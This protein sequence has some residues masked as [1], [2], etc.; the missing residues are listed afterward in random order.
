MVPFRI[1]DESVVQLRKILKLTS[2]ARPEH[3]IRIYISGLSQVGPEWN[4]SLDTY[5][6]ETDECCEFD[7]LR[8]IVERELLEAVGGLEVG[9]E[10]FDDDEAGGFVIT[11][12]DPNV[13][14]LYSDSCGC[15]GGCGGCGGCCHHGDEECDEEDHHCCGGGCCHHGDDDDD[16]SEDHHCHKRDG[17][18]RSDDEGECHPCRKQDGSC[19]RED[20]GEAHPCHKRDGS[21]R[22]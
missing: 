6:P 7:D 5:S 12:L 16:S 13:M 9:Y 3:A 19:Q 2:E 22:K 20:D 14:N 18:C 8:V 21:C 17:S 10:S 4:L 1:S 15:C 11:P